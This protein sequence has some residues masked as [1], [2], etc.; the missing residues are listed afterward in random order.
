M[1][2]LAELAVPELLEIDPDLGDDKAAALILKAR[3]P[4]FAEAAE[5]AAE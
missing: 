1:E 4:W 5:A 2:D 3:E